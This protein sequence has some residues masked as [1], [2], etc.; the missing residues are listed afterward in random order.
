MRDG[1]ITSIDTIVPSLRLE[2]EM[3]AM[4]VEPWREIQVGLPV[5][6]GTRASED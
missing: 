4:L 5:L 3:R 2:D 6:M 1:T